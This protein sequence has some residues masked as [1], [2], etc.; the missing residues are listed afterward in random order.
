MRGIATAQGGSTSNTAILARYREN[1]AQTE[2]E[3]Q[4][5][6]ALKVM[7]AQTLDAIVCT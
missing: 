7:P 4:S 1:V 2:T 6:E 3:R 5:F